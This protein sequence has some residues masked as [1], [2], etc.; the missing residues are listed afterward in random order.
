MG[1]AEPSPI[2]TRAA[3]AELVYEPE[4]GSGRQLTL[5]PASS[6]TR[7]TEPPVA[8]REQVVLLYLPE[9]A[10]AFGRLP[11]VGCALQ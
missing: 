1:C 5:A 6:L 2:E 7:R 8:S 11:L 4:F 10:N 3:S 9:F